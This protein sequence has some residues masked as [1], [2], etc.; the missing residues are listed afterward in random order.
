LVTICTQ[1]D[2]VD[3]AARSPVF[4]AMLSSGMK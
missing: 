2:H 4:R 3:L 1:S